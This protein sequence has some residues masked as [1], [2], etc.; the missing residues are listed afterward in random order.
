M[1]PLQGEET[2]DASSLGR[3]ERE[4]EWRSQEGVIMQRI[5]VN[6]LSV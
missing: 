4:R 3:R 2:E 5:K 1:R 6:G